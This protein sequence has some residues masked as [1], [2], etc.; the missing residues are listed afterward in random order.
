[1][2]LASN[3]MSRL[4]ANGP[5]MCGQAYI[6]MFADGWQRY[7]DIGSRYMSGAV[8]T[9]VQAGLGGERAEDLMLHA[10]RL[11]RNFATEAR[12]KSMR[13]CRQ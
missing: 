9:A 5:G 7:A 4:L 10:L 13:P 1:M 8:Q 12:L 11:G 6:S 3:L 2:S